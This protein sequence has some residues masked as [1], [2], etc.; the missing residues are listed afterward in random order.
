MATRRHIDEDEVEELYRDLLGAPGRIQ[1]KSHGVLKRGAVK[2]KEGMRRDFRNVRGV[3][4]H[5]GYYPHLSRAINFDRI[6]DGYEIGIDK[7]KVQGP[8]GNIIAFGTSH[9]APQVDKNAALRREIPYILRE[10]GE[11]GEES[12]LGDRSE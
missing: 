1:R 12:V 7:D 11:A 6:N 8:L 9:S 10:L 4:G 3:G 5:K 2:I